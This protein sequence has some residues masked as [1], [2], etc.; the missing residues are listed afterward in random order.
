MA[1]NPNSANIR[2]TDAANTGN[3]KNSAQ[4]KALTEQAVYMATVKAGLSVMVGLGNANDTVLTSQKFDPV[5]KKFYDTIHTRGLV[6]MRKAAMVAV[7]MDFIN[8]TVL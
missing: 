7:S 1:F 8:C 4:A 2:T 6:P 3:W 5:T